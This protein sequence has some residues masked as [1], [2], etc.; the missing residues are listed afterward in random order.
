MLSPF[1]DSALEEF[2]AAE[3][4]LTMAYSAK[5]RQDIFST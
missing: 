2:W 1:L 5:F 4:A 3:G